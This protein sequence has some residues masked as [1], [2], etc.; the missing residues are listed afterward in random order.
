MEKLGIDIL[1]EL[2]MGPLDRGHGSPYDRGRAD[3]YYRRKQRPHYRLGQV[4]IDEKNMTEEEKTQ[5][6]QGFLDNEKDGD[7]KNYGWQN[8]QDVL[9]YKYS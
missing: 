2:G 8:N 7:F 9:L 4:E 1:K 6:L 3:S 5:Y